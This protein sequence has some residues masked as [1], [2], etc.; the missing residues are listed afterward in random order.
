MIFTPDSLKRQEFNKSFRGFD[1]DEVRAFLE[2]LS[3]EFDALLVENETIKNDLE[4]TKQQLEKF[5]QAENK[6]QESLNEAKQT[7]NKLIEEAQHKAGEILRLA[8]EKSAELIQSS[9]EEADKL[10]SSIIKLRE[11]KE[12]IIAKLK[13]IIGYQT[14]L[15]ETRLV[16]SLEEIESP[17]K[18]EPQKGIEIN[19]D[20]IVQKLI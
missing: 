2:K 18:I 7:A 13:S 17:K 3:Y 4:L 15:F 8:E 14:H 6:I 16:E 10:K 1:K 9:R 19:V 20:E 12:I 5:L 11:E